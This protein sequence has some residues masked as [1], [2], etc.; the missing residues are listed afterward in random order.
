MFSCI[1][2]KM[3]Y[4]DVQEFIYTHKIRNNKTYKQ[5]HKTQR[6]MAK[7]WRCECHPSSPIFASQSADH[8]EATLPMIA[9]ASGR[10]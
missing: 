4:I 8:K 10:E 1:V 6:L 3:M 9:N 5:V 2:R 7:T